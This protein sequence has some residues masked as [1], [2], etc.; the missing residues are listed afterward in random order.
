MGIG[1]TPVKT[2]VLIEDNPHVRESWSAIINFERG[3]KVV[4]TFGSVE[5]ALESPILTSADLILLD[6]QLPGMSGVD[7]VKAIR[8]VVSDALIV[9]ATVN[10]DDANIFNALRNGAVGYLSKKISTTELIEAIRSAIDGGSPMSPSVARKVIAALQQSSRNE[11]D[12]LT[13]RERDILQ[14]LASGKSY[15][16][17]AREVHLSTNGVGYH[18]R[19]IY[20]K[21]QVNNR[22]EAVREGLRRRIIDLF[23]S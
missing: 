19:N 6:I 13:E 22:G 23:S 21:L 9:M 15:A 12:A 7:G 2:I 4:A 20:E 3:Y 5:E 18:V 14:R 8:K 16:A 10:E 17:I 11:A 1:G